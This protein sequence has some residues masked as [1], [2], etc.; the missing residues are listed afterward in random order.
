VRAL[1]GGTPSPGAA[2]GDEQAWWGRYTAVWVDRG[3]VS[4]MLA[5]RFCGLPLLHGVIGCIL[6]VV[7]CN[8]NRQLGTCT[9]STNCGL[10]IAAECDVL[11]T[12]G[13]RPIPDMQR[14]GCQLRCDANLA[15]VPA[16]CSDA[17][18]ELSLHHTG[19]PHQLQVSA[20]LRWFGLVRASRGY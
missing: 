9:R 4:L 19:Q 10:P 13:S 5:G 1:W 6:F 14:V 2:L 12:T 18:P 16:L 20:A 11:A 15:A 3:A 7:Q 8:V 17:A